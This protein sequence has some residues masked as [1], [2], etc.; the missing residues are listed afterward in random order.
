MIKIISKSEKETKLL[1]KKVASSLK[2]GE[3]LAL[4]GEL[5]A[6]K[7]FFTQSLAH[8]LGVKEKITSP[9]FILLKTYR[10]TGKKIKKI[11]HLDAYRLK[12]A[13]DLT[14]LGI[15]EFLGAKKSLTVIEW[16]DKVKKI[17]PAKT[18][19]IKI[20]ILSKDKLRE[21]KIYNYPATR[22]TSSTEVMP[23]KVFKTPS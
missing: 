12:S 11:Y 19:F 23:S 20:K 3:I 8:I 10:A 7:T 22:K 17:L 21:F 15:L 2:G 13:N 9:T 16:A 18:L 5:G 6:G 14:D 1:A 4:I